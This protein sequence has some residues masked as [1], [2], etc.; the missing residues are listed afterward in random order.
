MNKKEGNSIEID[1][2]RLPK[3]VAIIMDGNGRWAT[4][5]RKTRAAGHR[6]GAKT[7]EDISRAAQQMGIEHLTVYAFSTENWIRPEDEIGALMG[8]LREY[9]VQRI[10]EA[11]KDSVKVH[12]M[13]DLQRLDIDLQQKIADLHE[14]TKDK[15][16]MTLH[17]ALNYGGRDE[18]LRAVKGLVKDCKEKKL[19]VKNIDEGMFQSYLDTCGVPDPELLIRTS[20]EQRIS[21][22]L[23]WQLAYAELY[24]SDKLWP[25]FQPEDLY[26]AVH[27]FQN[28]S[29]RFGGL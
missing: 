27:A 12:I 23:L 11:K 28:R 19:E 5:K 4:K 24:F 3:H 15:P 18:I 14:V 16:G 20:G 6:A 2:T 25:D 1:S 10:R 8:L 7:L 13:G 21:N 9:L 17:I 22:F 26:K 29:R